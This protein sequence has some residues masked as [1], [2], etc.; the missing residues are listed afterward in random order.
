MRTATRRFAAWVA[1]LAVLFGAAAPTF[2]RAMAAWQGDNAA[3]TE[4]CTSAGMVRI[5]VPA[6]DAPEGSGNGGIA[7]D[8][9]CPYCLMQACSPALPGAARLALPAAEPFR[10]LPELA[11]RSPRPLFAWA[12]AQP[13]APPFAS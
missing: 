8:G 1:L 2:A 13:R 10:P 11:Y 4:I 12:T 3:W 7:V 6:G 5:A 9:D